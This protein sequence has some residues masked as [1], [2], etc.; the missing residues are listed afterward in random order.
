MKIDDQEKFSMFISDVA[1]YYRTNVSEFLITVWF[2]GLIEYEFD[3]VAKAARD[4]AKNAKNGHFMPKVSDIIK[5]I[6]ESKKPDKFDYLSSEQAWCIA[7]DYL[8]DENKAMLVDDVITASAWSVNNLLKIGD[9]FGAQKAF[10]SHYDGLVSEAKK[11]G[12]KRKFFVSA[13]SSNI[14][15]AEVARKAY[16]EGLISIDTVIGYE[17]KAMI[18][19]DELSNALMLIR[20]EI[21]VKSIDTSKIKEVYPALIEKLK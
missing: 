5:I 1:S 3:D 6:N 13:G 20:N 7:V 9:K 8:L 2:E 19:N 17:N 14:E 12:F 10:I 4:Y 18:T 21:D 16:S 15:T 11:N